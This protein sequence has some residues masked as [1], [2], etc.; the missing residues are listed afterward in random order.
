MKTVFILYKDNTIV[1]PLT[2]ALSKFEKELSIIGTSEVN[3]EAKQNCSFS[4]PNYI[5]SDLLS[6]EVAK[7]IL[8]ICPST[9]LV[10]IADDMNRGNSIITSLQKDGL[11][12]AT[13]A[14][15]SVISPDELCQSLLT[16]DKN[17]PVT[18][19]DSVASMFDNASNITLQDIEDISKSMPKTTGASSEATPENKES[20]PQASNQ[21]IETP[22]EEN[23]MSG[24]EI[25][26]NAKNEA[27]NLNINNL[28]SKTISVFSKKGG[29]GKTTLV[30]ELANVYSSVK[31]PKKLQNGNEYLTAC[32]VDFDFDRGNLRTY[33]GIDNPSPNIYLWMNDILDKIENKTEVNN[34]VFNSFDVMRYVKKVTS[35]GN[36]YT[37]ITAQGGIPPR[38]LSRIVELDQ[39]GTL[40]TD[41]I[42]IIFTSLRK[43][44]DVVIFDMD[45][46]FNE[47]TRTV[48]S[49]SDNILYVLNPTNADVE[50]LKV[51][52]DE[53]EQDEEGLIHL[54]K[55]G[56]VLNKF[57]KGN[58]FKDQLLDILSLVKY[59]T[60]NYQ[61]G[62]TS[63][64]NYKF[65][66]TITEDAKITNYNNGF[67]FTTTASGG[68]TKKGF[69]KTCEYCLPIF[70][71]KHTTTGLAELEKIKAK[72][73][74]L[75]AKKQV[76]EKT[77]KVEKEI[78]NK[79]KAEA[80]E[81]TTSINEET[82]ATLKTGAKDYVL[83]DLSNV[84]LEEFVE[85]LKT[86]SD[87]PKL[88]N[89]F[90]KV[91][92]KPPK[93]PNSVFKAY[94]KQ[95]QKEVKMCLK[96]RSTKK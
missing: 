28:R 65:A 13:V 10:M 60:I 39:T 15:A 18:E 34:I 74:K 53:V 12:N 59:K 55:V 63:T 91:S 26:Q 32:T 79:L 51:F 89:G 73:K 48:L 21:P 86:F 7:E 35:D 33:Y 87:C 66:S 11:F 90:P 69:L 24:I 75:E 29:T 45:N 42:K 88:K 76:K 81:G 83:S 84:G 67:L 61:T 70:K 8:E 77:K 80:K 27:F 58:T 36:Y 93:L 72:K 71:V 43:A 50:N 5:L 37:L 64:K 85:T 52:T 62:E 92:R 82:G 44:F 56:L 49:M 96:L 19:T 20:E 68:E 38:T 95:L 94:S 54:D 22:K 57:S 2:R 4:S 16:L 25:R 78:E 40:L 41:I 9:K 47:V 46:D 14:D 6:Q 31:L 1:N 30:K 17:E 23:K 3:E